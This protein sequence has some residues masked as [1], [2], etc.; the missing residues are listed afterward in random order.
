M[1]LIFALFVY[2]FWFVLLFF[3]SVCIF[4]VYHSAK[5]ASMSYH[6][7]INLRIFECRSVQKKN[8]GFSK[9]NQSSSC[10][11]QML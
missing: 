11:C 4:F 9:S 2:L 7:K 6:P 3:L 1:T 8:V 10:L 5:D